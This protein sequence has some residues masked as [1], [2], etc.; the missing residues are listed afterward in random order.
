[1]VGHLYLCLDAELGQPF[2]GLMH[3]LRAVRQNQRPLAGPLNQRREHGRLA[4]ARG[5]DPKS[6]LLRLPLS[7]DCRNGVLLIRS[8]R[9]ADCRWK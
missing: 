4:E 3:K 7:Q 6:R 5:R 1:M 8:E 9:L 2:P